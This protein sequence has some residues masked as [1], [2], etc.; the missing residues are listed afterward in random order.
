MKKNV[1]SLLIAL[2]SLTVMAQNG[3]NY[4]LYDLSTGL[5]S[6]SISFENPSGEPGKG[7]TA[8]S[9]DLGVGRKGFP[10][11]GIAPGETVVLC[12]IH[13]SGTIRHIWM[14]GTFAK[15]NFT[16]ERERNL[17]LRSTLIRAYWDGQEHPSI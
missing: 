14:T 7:G 2:L 17:L 6:R 3:S 4:D 12:D 1:F 13:N 9:K 15:Q 16:P 8:A 10:A 11:K 5:K